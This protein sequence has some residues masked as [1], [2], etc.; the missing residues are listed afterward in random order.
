MTDVDVVVVGGG[1]NG[2]VCAAYLARAGQRVVVLE[3]R[4]L[5]G[6]PAGTFEFLPGYSTSFTNSP[7]S[8][9][10]RIIEELRLHDF[11]LRF[12]APTPSLVH[13]FPGAAFLGWRDRTLVDQQLDS[14]ARGE[15]TRYREFVGALEGLGQA[16]GVSLYAPPPTLDEL[17]QRMAS[18]EWA[19]LYKEVFYGSLE[20]LLQ[21]RLRSPQAKALLAMLALNGNLIAPTAAGSAIGLMMRPI[22]MASGF[23][24]QR[25]SSVFRGS[26]GLPAGGMGAIVGALERAVLA[27]GGR[28]VTDT[29][30]V[31]ITT[32][33]HGVQGV[34]TSEGDE[35]LANRV[36]SAISPVST[37]GTLLADSDLPPEIQDIRERIVKSSPS[38][39]TFKI[40]LALDGVPDYADL[41]AGVQSEDVSAAQFRIGPSYEY[42]KSSITDAL[43][44]IPT[45]HPIMWGLMVSRTS[46][47]LAPPGRQLLSVNAWHAPYA[48][49][50]GTWDEVTTDDFGTRCIEALTQLMPSLKNHIIGHRFMNP[51]DVE[52]ELFLDG[53]NITHGDMSVES[54]FGGRPDPAV[55]TSKTPLRGLYLGGAGTWPGGYVTGI[56]GRNASDAILQETARH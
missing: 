24:D 36:V 3:R 33:A 38:G 12:L 6:G 1:H 27:A 19:P 8:F 52:R 17:D 44:G 18:S 40:V 31:R 13:H 42:V 22:S 32:N 49:A 25:T 21:T 30:V 15:A 5:L 2:L 16:L 28:V 35:I 14:F 26:S 20:S 9:E 37:F 50:N 7:G 43:H 55:R 4:R 39:S 48:L 51:V 23:N 56:P 11:G 47:E 53:S 45:E 41:P 54:L 46:P 34:V 10:R 29:V